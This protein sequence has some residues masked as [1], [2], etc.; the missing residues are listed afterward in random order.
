MASAWTCVKNSLQLCVSGCLVTSALSGI[1]P[2]R[3]GCYLRTI[4]MPLSFRRTLLTGVASVEPACARG[5]HQVPV[6]PAGHAAG[7]TL[8]ASLMLTCAIC[9]VTLY[10]DPRIKLKMVNFEVHGRLQIMH[11]CIR[12]GV[13]AQ[14]CIARDCQ[15]VLQVHT[16]GR[17]KQVPRSDA[18]CRTPRTHHS[19]SHNHPS[20][21]PHAPTWTYT[22]M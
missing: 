14:L 2:T 11:C 12:S 20:T 1:R 4:K 5:K 8:R 18:T 3:L 21:L 19:D 9:A 6:A 17:W 10:L 13:Q 22:H 15:G 16:P 7:T